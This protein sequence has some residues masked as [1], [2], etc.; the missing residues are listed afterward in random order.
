MAIAP[1]R[2]NT[3]SDVPPQRNAI[4]LRPS[5]FSGFDVKSCIP[6]GHSVGRRNAAEFFQRSGED[7]GRRFRAVCIITRHVAIDEIANI[8]QVDVILCVS[9]F[10]GTGKHNPSVVVVNALKKFAHFWER[11][12]LWKIFLSK[13]PGPVFIQ[14]FA[15]TFD[16]LRR[17]KCR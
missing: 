2:R 3:D 9:L 14:V 17:E 16:L 8:K 4:V 5:L 7:I 12:D 13:Q 10:A 1:A 15:E 6:N 11:P